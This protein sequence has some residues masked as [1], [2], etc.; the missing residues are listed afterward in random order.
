[1]I[2]KRHGALGR[3]DNVREQQRR[4]HPIRLGVMLHAGQKRLDLI[5]DRIA[6]PMEG[7]MVDTRQLHELRVRDLL[8]QMP[9]PT[10]LHHP[11]AGAV[12][13]QG[14]HA[15]SGQHRPDIDRQIHA[16]QRHRP[17]RDPDSNGNAIHVRAGSCGGHWLRSPWQIVRFMS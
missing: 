12:Q 10:D 11:I 9:A 2:A 15:D 8:S 1:M 17:V 5:N 16:A 6:V 7:R 13:H 3:A 14:W 4:Q